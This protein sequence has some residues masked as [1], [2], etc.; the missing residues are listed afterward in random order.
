MSAYHV[1]CA[2]H[3]CVHDPVHETQRPVNS[4]SPPN[5][6]QQ[7]GTRGVAAGGS[8]PSLAPVKAPPPSSVKPAGDSLFHGPSCAALRVPGSVTNGFAQIRV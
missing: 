4:V 6:G 7:T 8:L 2:F 1:T 5:N 3:L